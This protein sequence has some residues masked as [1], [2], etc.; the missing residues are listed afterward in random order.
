MGASPGESGRERPTHPRWLDDDDLRERENL[1][2]LAG[3]AELA[4]S[5][6]EQGFQGPDYEVF[7]GVTIRYGV[8]V[9]RGWAV[10]GLLL[11]K[12]L[13]KKIR[14]MPLE[15][16]RR[17]DYDTADEL[18]GESVARAL[19]PFRVK[20]LLGGKWNPRRGAAMKTYFVT[21]CL[22]KATD[23]VTGWVKRERLIDEEARTNGNARLDELLPKKPVTDVD[24]VLIEMETM[25]AALSSVTRPEART[26]LVM[27]SHDWTIPEIAEKNWAW[28]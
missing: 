19:E 16:S 5:L 8:G 1:D 12:A 26:A 2:R 24:R 6:R 17:F 21:G 11:Q 20:A 10:K 14:G 9:L 13:E 4:A 15:A 3:D 22:I 23:V 7:E 25:A 18:A 28:A 27:L